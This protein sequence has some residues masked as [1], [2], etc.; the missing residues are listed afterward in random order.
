MHMLL[1]A[2]FGLAIGIVAKFVMGGTNPGGIIVTSL[3]GLAGGFVGGRIG[4][5]LGWYNEGSAAGFGLSVVGAMVL[6]LAYR[7]F[8]G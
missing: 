7:M 5:M 4:R 8:I 3:L 6:L 2:L 1:H